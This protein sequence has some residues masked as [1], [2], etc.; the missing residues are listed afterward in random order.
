MHET[1]AGLSLQESAP[2]VS[3]RSDQV[4]QRRKGIRK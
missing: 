2:Y 3:E 4:L 1:I